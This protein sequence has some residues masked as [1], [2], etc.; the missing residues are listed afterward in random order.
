[1]DAFGRSLS[2]VIDAFGP[3]FKHHIAVKTNPLSR[4]LRVIVE[5]GM[6]L[7]C[8]SIGEVYHSLKCGAKP[9]DVVYDSPVKTVAE[10]EYCLRSGVHVNCD[11]LQELARVR[12]MIRMHPQLLDN[13]PVIGLR[14]NPLVGEGA[15]KELSVSGIHSKFG[16]PFALEDPEA[17]EE[18]L[19][20][21]R[22]NPFVSCIHVHVG[23]QGCDLTLMAKGVR[24]VA[25]LA[26]A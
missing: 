11:N 21:V 1:M 9:C 24:L 6:G 3:G 23:S 18:A 16:T 15:I 8:A 22:N 12:E 25:Q 26:Q 5:K 4:M 14:I 7:E 2:L 20:L 17:F 10:L 13:Q 19:S